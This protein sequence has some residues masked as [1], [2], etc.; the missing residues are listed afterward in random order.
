MS[1]V[2]GG[3]ARPPPLPEFK[4]QIKVFDEKLRNNTN[5]FSITRHYYITFVAP[6]L[7]PLTGHAPAN[8]LHL[9]EIKH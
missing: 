6:K 9:S 4:K 1:R 5:N 7:L 2:D 8:P 3:L